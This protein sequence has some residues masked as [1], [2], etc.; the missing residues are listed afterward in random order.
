MNLIISRI[1]PLAMD[2]TGLFYPRL[3]AACDRLLVRSEEVVCLYCRHDLPETGF[4][5]HQEN[6]VVRHF[7]G[8]VPFHHAEVLYSFL[9]G[10]KV[11][12]LLHRLKYQNRPEIG[13][14][15]GYYYGQ[16]LGES[17]Y[18][19]ETD[20]IIPVPLHPRKEH[21][22]GYNQSAMFAPGMAESMR[23]KAGL[24]TLKRVKFTG[25]RTRHS[26]MERWSNV[27]E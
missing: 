19:Q 7:W 2:L 16:R 4:H 6:P 9:K 20:L 12:K 17:P 14:V 22:R 24:T 5:L 21:K 15:L 1:M 18:Y 13:Q 8:R 23:I 26:R 27:E 3:C 25:S 10:G 11:Q